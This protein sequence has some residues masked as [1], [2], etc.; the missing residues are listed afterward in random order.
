MSSQSALVPPLTVTLVIPAYN[1]SNYL[2]LCLEHL[3]RSTVPFECIVVDDGSTDDTRAVADTF[4][5][6]V[7]T[8]GG[9]RGPAFAR[10]LGAKEATTD[11]VYFIDADVCVHASTLRLLVL[12]LDE[13]REID[14]VFGAYDTA[15]AA[16]GLAPYRT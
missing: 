6:K 9:R 12:E 10:N 16:R 11:L 5:V 3:F 8:T 15:P 2:R 4:G 13:R 14:A 7:L 1:A